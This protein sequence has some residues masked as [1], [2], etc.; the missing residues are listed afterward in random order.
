MFKKIQILIKII[1]I[2]QL[3][4]INT[5]YFQSLIKF[6]QR[7]VKIDLKG[8]CS[9]GQKMLSSIVIRL[10][11]LEAFSS[12]CGVLA[13][14]EPTQNLDVQHIQSLCQ[15]LKQLIKKQ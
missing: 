6:Q 13:L 5:I 14:D 3:I 9:M 10:A 12:N 15:S 8:R 7:K 4:Q 11:L 2:I 1:D